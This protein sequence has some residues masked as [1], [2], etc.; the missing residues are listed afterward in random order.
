MQLLHSFRNNHLDIRAQLPYYG[1]WSLLL[2]IAAADITGWKVGSSPFLTIHQAFPDDPTLVGNPD[3]VPNNGSGL[4]PLLQ[5]YWMVIHPPTLFLGF[6]SMTVPFAFVVAG[7][8]KR[9]YGAWVKPAMPWTLLANLVLGVGIIMGGYWAY[10]TLNFGG[11]WNWDPVENASL[12]P[13]IVSVGALHTMLAWQKGKTNLR[14]SMLLVVTAFVLVLYSTFLTRS[15]I[16]GNAS[17]HSFTDLG[18]SG[19]LLVLLFVYLGGVTLLFFSVWHLLPQSK[20]QKQLLTRQ[21]FLYA[22]AITLTASAALIITLTSMPV[23]NAV[24]GTNVAPPAEVPRYY[25]QWTIWFGILIA[26]LSGVGQYF[27][28]TKVEKQALSK[29]LFRPFMAAVLATIVVLLALWYYGWEFAFNDYFRE[30]IELAKASGST[31]D[32]VYYQI[33]MAIMFVADELLLVTGVFTVF[34]NLDILIRLT[35]KNLKHL[36]RIGGSLAHIGIALILIGVLF[37][38]GYET[39]ISTTGIDQ[40]LSANLP[41]DEKKD[42]V[43]LVLNRPVDI[44]NYRVMY[45]GRNY[46]REPIGDVKVIHQ[47]LGFIQ[48]GFR[49]AQGDRYQLEPLP[50]MA[51]GVPGQDIEPMENGK[52]PE[53]EIDQERL[54]KFVEQEYAYFEPELMN[55][56]TIFRVDFIPRGDSGQL[57][58]KRAFSVFPETELDPNENI[59]SHP[60]RKIKPQEDVYVHVSGVMEDEDY[61]LAQSGVAVDVGAQT[62]ETPQGER[63]VADTVVIGNNVK[64]VVD[65][66]VEVTDIPQYQDYDLVARAYVKVMHYDQEYFARPTLMLDGNRLIPVDADIK[67]LAMRL[68]FARVDVEND[69]ILLDLYSRGESILINAIRKPY[70]NIL[71]L[72]TFFLAGGFILAIFRRIRER[73]A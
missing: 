6:A 15:G 3:F 34:A 50:A 1:L 56:R 54:S 4:N 64:L 53:I 58:F 37:S 19:Q 22:A 61:R 63:M 12:V 44:K 65:S 70:I 40:P 23:F 62:V 31:F 10:E 69:K 16:L 45:R 48:V 46:P 17:V 25:Y 43:Q 27:F 20:P 41:E 13:W 57:K 71:W 21:N 67:P 30:K 11:Y 8:L 47:E 29:A 7:L 52:L 68:R 28:W 24:F 39:T 33:G 49:D 26:L 55:S 51:F 60:D 38:A 35:A 9:Q 2:I 73:T 66:V 14:T 59:I 32:Y 5:N 72:G 18:L 36:K 42:H